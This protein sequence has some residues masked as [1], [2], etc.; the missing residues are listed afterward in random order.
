MFYGERIRVH[1][2]YNEVGVVGQY[3]IDATNKRVDVEVMMDVQMERAIDV[4]VYFKGSILSRLIA[5]LRYRRAIVKLRREGVNVE[6][7]WSFLK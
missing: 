6:R 4:D 7:L 5:Y 2:T 3:I 1:G